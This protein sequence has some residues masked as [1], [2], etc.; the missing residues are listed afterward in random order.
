MARLP[1]QL[2]TLAVW[3]GTCC[4]LGAP[5]LRNLPRL[6]VA[7]AIAVPV[8]LLPARQD[9]EDGPAAM[10]DPE[11]RLLADSFALSETDLFRARH[12]RRLAVD[13]DGGGRIVALRLP[14]PAPARLIPDRDAHPVG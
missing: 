4:L 12:A 1:G 13:H 8:L 6:A 2:L 3:S 9:S 7:G 5:L 10:A 11:R 14:D